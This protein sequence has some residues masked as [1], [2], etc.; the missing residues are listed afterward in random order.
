M[1]V[2]RDKHLYGADRGR[3]WRAFSESASLE[4]LAEIKGAGRRGLTPSGRRV[5]DCHSSRTADAARTLNHAA[6]RFAFSILTPGINSARARERP[7]RPPRRRWRGPRGGRDCIHLR[8]AAAINSRGVK[9]H[10]IE[11]LK[12][13]WGRAKRSSREIGLFGIRAVFPQGRPPTVSL[14]N[15][16]RSEEILTLKRLGKY[17]SVLRLLQ[18]FDENERKFSA[19]DVVR[20]H[21]AVRWRQDYPLTVRGAPGPNVEGD[22]MVSLMRFTGVRHLSTSGINIQSLDRDSSGE[23]RD[24]AEEKKASKQ[25]KACIRLVLTASFVRPVVKMRKHVAGKSKKAPAAVCSH[26]KPPAEAGRLDLFRRR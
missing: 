11:A 4:S 14:D 8:S 2:Y 19:G 12:R 13:E 18:V 26:A 7:A 21:Y 25:T 23:E 22:R 17:D 3:Q 15:G 20:H 6:E 10:N 24:G 16:A 1:S 5:A 9:F